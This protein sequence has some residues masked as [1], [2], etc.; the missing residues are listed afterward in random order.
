VSAISET[1]GSEANKTMDGD[2]LT[3]WTA[4]GDQKWIRYDLGAVQTVNGVGTAWNK[5]NARKAI[6]DVLVSIDGVNWTTVFSGRSSGT[7]LE[8]ENQYFPDIQARYVQVM[9][10]G[11]TDSG[12][13]SLGEIAIYGMS[14]T[15][16]TKVLTA[17]Q[18]SITDSNGAP[19]GSLSSGDAVVTNVPVTNEGQNAAKVTLAASLY[20][21]D[22]H[23]ALKYEKVVL[24]PGET[25]TLR[26]SVNVPA[27]ADGCFLNVFLWDGMQRQVIPSSVFPQ[28][29]VSLKSITIDGTALE[30]FDPDQLT[31]TIDPSTLTAEGVPQVA[32]ETNSSAALVTII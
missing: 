24:Q 5:G 29:D 27:D 10:H 3:Y 31:Y 23:L 25:K 12:W 9:G 17:G 8:I 20:R 11:N 26:V 2:L 1:P 22:A 4:E 19:A 18:V 21:D 32:A 13:N 16:D 6:Y 7:T 14:S 30:G 15:S 28:Q